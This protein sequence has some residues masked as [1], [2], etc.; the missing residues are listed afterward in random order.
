MKRLFAIVFLMIYL[1]NWGGYLLL[2]NYMVQQAD[3][4]MN[5]LISEGLYDPNSLIE[6]KIKQ[7]LPGIFEW[8]D[9]KNV[10][11][12]LQ[13]K[14]A[15]YNYVKLKFTKDTLYVMCVPNY[16]KTKLIKSNII[17]AKQLNDIPADKKTDGASVKKTGA[18]SKY[19]HHVAI[20]NFMRFRNIPPQRWKTHY[21]LI[22][23]P[24]IP[25]PGQP[26]EVLS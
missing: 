13:L 6:V 9:Y 26:P 17:Y 20:F 18:D 24:Y 10:S 19:D 25:V 8:N 12:Q 1:F 23:D 15:C 2:Q 22:S 16:E 14:N 5:Q 3:S 7:H 21:I 11:G 4:R